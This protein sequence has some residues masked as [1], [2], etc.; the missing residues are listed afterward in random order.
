MFADAERFWIADDGTTSPLA[1]GMRDT[2]VETDDAWPRTRLLV[3]F[4]HPAAQGSRVR[5]TLALFDRSGRPALDR[6][7]DIHLMEDVETGAVDPADAVDGV[8]EI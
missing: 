6:Y 1:E 2:R 5:R 4:A 3:S 8:I 7:A